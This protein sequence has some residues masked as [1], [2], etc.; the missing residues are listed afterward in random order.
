MT[1]LTRPV[2]EFEADWSNRPSKAFTYDLREVSLGFG[3][4]FFN[5]LQTHVVQGYAFTVLLE[6]AAAVLAFDEFTAALK[7][8]LAGFWLPTPLQAMRVVGAV[9]ATQFDIADQNLRDTLADHP[10]VYI[11]V[12][13]PGQ[14]AQACKINAVVLQSAGIERVTLTEA[15][16]PA[17]NSTCAISRLH[18]VRLAGDEERGTFLGEGLQRREVRV[19]ELP[20]EYE[21]FETGESPIW[22]YHFFTEAPMDTHW[23]FTSFAAAVVSNNKLFAA[24]PIQHR[25]LRDTAR[26]EARTVDIEAKFDAN[27][28]LALLLPIPPSKPIRIEILRTTL[29]DPNTT[30]VEF[31]GFI[32]VPTDDGDK[33]VG[34]AASYWSLLMTRKFPQGLIQTE[35]ETDIFD[36]TIG[37]VAR[38]KFECPAEILAV[39]NAAQ[40]PTVT[41]EFTRPEALQAPNWETADW[42][43]GGYVT[44]GTGTAYQVRTILSSAFAADELTLEL[45]APL[46]ADVGARALVIPGYDGSFA[47][48]RDKF[49]DPDNFGGFPVVVER[50]LSLQAVDAIVS[51][52]GKK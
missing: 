45:N 26:L 6:D 28:P 47:Q 49:K 20:H 25:G 52:G 14:A 46:A 8:P 17:V 33:A 43:A 31:T 12:T 10:D 9:S 16:A 18:Y 44:I 3:A 42:F 27:H 4:E 7:G 2:F 5:R 15:L 1:Y 29:A 30:T 34:K 19:I 22:L 36:E 23:R 39:D 41:L 51:Q 11:Y 24:F 32:K 38:W 48:R 21:A 37:G 13:R 50:N 35:D 40:P